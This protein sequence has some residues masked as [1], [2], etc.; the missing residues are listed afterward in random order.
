VPV[1]WRRKAA[2]SP[3]PRES[4]AGARCVPSDGVE[5]RRFSRSGWRHTGARLSQPVVTAI[6][7]VVRPKC[8]AVSLVL[9]IR[10]SPTAKDLMSRPLQRCHA[11][12]CPRVARRRSAVIVDGRTD[13]GIDQSA[14]FPLRAR[15]RAPCRCFIVSRVCRSAGLIAVGVRG[16]GGVLA[17]RKS[18][19][20]RARA[21]S[22]FFAC[23][24]SARLTTVSTRSLVTARPASP[25]R[26]LFTSG[27]SELLP[28]SNRSSTA[29]ASFLAF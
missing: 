27:G 13:S 4:G 1:T 26:R 9:A 25:I 22:R 8:D 7:H 28:I 3:N 15:L 5:T 10:R 21:L 20:S 11:T 29:V 2:S 18:V 16:V 14:I 12:W 6:P 17:R 19:S 23:D 24:R